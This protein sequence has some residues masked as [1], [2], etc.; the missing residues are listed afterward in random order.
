[1]RGRPCQRG[2][3]SSARGGRGPRR[4]RAEFDVD[5]GGQALA[6]GHLVR[7]MLVGPEEHD[8]RLLAARAPRRGRALGAEGGFLDA[9]DGLAGRRRQR[10]A[11]D[12]LQLVDRAGRAGAAGHDAAARARVDRALDGGLGLVQQPR[13]AAAGDVVLGVGVGVGLQQALQVALDEAQRAPRGGVVAV[14]HRPA[15]EGGLDRRVHADDLVAQRGEIDA[16]E[17]HG[18]PV[19]AGPWEP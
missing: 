7:V 8:R 11:E 17:A 5:H 10:H 6:P 12:A 9:L 3:V 15:A 14:D 16:R 19:A 2:S 18:I 4:R 13:H 1:M